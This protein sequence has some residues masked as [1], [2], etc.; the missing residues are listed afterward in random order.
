MERGELRTHVIN[1]LL[2]NIPPLVRNEKEVFLLTVRV[3]K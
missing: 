1:K 2:T 3:G